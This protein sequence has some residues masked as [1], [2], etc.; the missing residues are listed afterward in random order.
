MAAGDWRKSDTAPASSFYCRRFFTQRRWTIY[1]FLSLQCGR[2]ILLCP[3]CLL[4][5]LL[6]YRKGWPF[7]YAWA[8]FLCTCHP[9]SVHFLTNSG[10]VARPIKLWAERDFWDRSHMAG[11][12]RQTH[13]ASRPQF[14]PYLPSLCAYSTDST[15]FWGISLCLCYVS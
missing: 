7:Y 14:F 13:A 12:G 3:F 9:A 11:H 8:F 4:P 5:T 15:L 6:Y 10:M 1:L 2:H